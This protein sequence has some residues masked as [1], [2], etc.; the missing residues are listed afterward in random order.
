M[1]ATSLQFL[2]FSLMLLLAPVNLFDLGVSVHRAIV[3]EIANLLISIGRSIYVPKAAQRT[4][5]S[6]ILYTSAATCSGARFIHFVGS[7]HLRLHRCKL[8]G[9]VQQ[10]RAQGKQL[11]TATAVSCTLYTK[12]GKCGLW[13]KVSNKNSED[14]SVDGNCCLAASGYYS[15]VC[16][17]GRKNSGAAAF[18][19]PSPLIIPEHTPLGIQSLREVNQSP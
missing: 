1:K 4:G 10:F 5:L 11:F 18:P 19:L 2:S 14:T 9:S 7:G 8:A 16:G 15:V 6:R 12:T 17:S 3:L 13:R